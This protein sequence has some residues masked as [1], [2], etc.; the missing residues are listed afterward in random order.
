MTISV[1][2]AFQRDLEPAQGSQQGCSEQAARLFGAE[3]LR[4][5]QKLARRVAPRG[6]DADDL[7]HDALERALRNID[8][9][10]AGTNLYAWMRTRGSRWTACAASAAAASTRST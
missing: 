2:Y 9:F 4:R 6:V 3:E 1:A 8:R 7:L 10:Q 5:L